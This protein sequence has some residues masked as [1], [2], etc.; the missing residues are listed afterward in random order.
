MMDFRSQFELLPDIAYVNHGSFG[1]CPIAVSAAAQKWR[2]TMES[3]PYEF[4][5]D[6]LPGAIRDAVTPLAEFIGAS[7]NDV[8]FVDNATAGMNAV[9]RSFDW[10]PGDE[11]VVTE[12]VYGGVSKV[13][14]YL[15]ASRGLSVV[16]V[17]VPW[18]I[19]GA[20]AFDRHI[21][22]AVLSA[23]TPRTRMVSIDLIASCSGLIF[24]VTAIVQAV[25][26]RGV[27]VL[28]D[29]AHGP[30]QMPIDV[31]DL[32]A[33]WLT[34][35]CHKWL[36]APKGT[37]FLW[38]HPT[39]SV[40]TE[41]HPGVVTHGY[42]QG[43]LEEFDFVGT[44]DYSSWLAMPAA[45]EWRRTHGGWGIAHANHEMVALMSSM[46][47]ELWGT[48]VGAPA[49]LFG[50]LATIALPVNDAGTAEAARAFRDRLWREHRVE[51]GVMGFAGRLW[52]RISAQVYNTVDDY[53]RLGA[54]VADLAQERK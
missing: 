23:L 33:D 2:S 47:A 48:F 51:A 13:L 12:H 9:L 36:F 45:L 40:A 42:S 52:C 29:A 19:T 35:N 18:P 25:H 24:P 43:W 49:E 38:A 14:S 3:Q 10:Q 16:T 17:P 46:L 15:A 39:R 11:I 41:L 8:V 1:G 22:D 6:V 20:A 4:F 34:G 50:S 28:V 31:N 32:D 54:A 44:R 21:V 7:A 26:A 30:G 53:E 5:V 27:Q 37:A